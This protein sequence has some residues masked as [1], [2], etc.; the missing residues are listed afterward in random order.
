MLRD[1]RHAF[2]LFAQQPLVTVIA[3]L[4]LAIGTGA[5][6]AIFSI[7]NTVL[8]APLPFHDADRLTMIWGFG[9]QQG[10]GARPVSV[11]VF[12]EWK[13]RSTSFEKIASSSDGQYSLTGAGDP[14]SIVGYRFDADF[15]DLLGV[16]PMLGRTFLPEDTVL[17]KHQVVVLSHRLWQR[18]FGADP[19]I[20]GRAIT[21]NGLSYNVIGVMPAGFKHPQRADIWAPLVVVGPIQENW[22]ARPL[23]IAGRLKPG[24]TIE[25][26]QAEMTRIGSELARLNPSSNATET[27]QVMS[28]RENLTGDIRPALLMLM[29]AASFI[30]LITCTNL[31]NLLLAR[32]SVR[33]TEMAIRSALGASRTMLIRQLMTESIVLAV[34]GSAIGF[35]LT[36]LFSNVLVAMFPNNIANLSIPQV[37]RLSIDARVLGFTLLIAILTAITFGI[38]PAFHALRTSLNQRTAVQPPARFRRGLLVAEIALTLVLLAG[39]GLMLRS[40]VHVLDS[41]LGFDPTNRLAVQVML[42]N[43]RYDQSAKFAVFTDAVIQRLKSLPGVESVGATNYLPLSGFWGTT[44]AYAEGQPLPKPGDE[45]EVDSRVATPDYFAT[46][47]IRVV[48]GRAFTERDSADA[49]RVVIVS[50]GLAERLWPGADPIGRRVSLSA[51]KP[52][53][54]EVVGVTTDVKAFGQEEE[55]HLD[56]FRPFAQAPF[57]LVAFVVHTAAA[58]ATLF[59]PVREQIWA[60]DRDLPMFR[61]NTMEQ[62]AAESTALRRISLQLLVGFAALALLLAAVG[63]YGVMAYSVS[64]RFQEIG[65]RMALGAERLTIMRL[66]IGEVG[67]IAATGA[68]IGLAAAWGVSRLASSL[69]V[70]VSATDPAVYATA[71]VVLLAVTF[72]AGY[73]PA[74]RAGRI[75]PMVALRQQ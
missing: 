12:R 71:T 14:V 74:R 31:A 11:P 58:P 8:L 67:W 55:T 21:L 5:N 10:G 30:L 70:N 48:R 16:R 72:L 19:N 7:V 50:Q 15:F 53:W 41:D 1:I 37:E 60:V 44:T 56:L 46:M 27:V 25:Q 9:T 28:F 61:E 34:V 2:R 32:A 49:P 4:V 68:V 62:L 39:A 23:R 40:F 17:G 69:M 18:H 38:V 24:V 66:I 54:R 33:A 43:S 20:V 26:A 36:I 29:G 59:A 51:T 3:V 73:L 35:G 22:N 42:P 65:I 57:S 6:T 45:L 13:S 64:Q 52:E 63:T 47:G 75:A